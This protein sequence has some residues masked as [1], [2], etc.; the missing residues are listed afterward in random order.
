MTHIDS[1][2][3]QCSS[4]LYLCF[5]AGYKFQTVLTKKVKLFAK[6]AQQPQILMCVCSHHMT[7][8]K[9]MIL[10]GLHVHLNMNVSVFVCFS[11]I[12]TLS[13]L[14]EGFLAVRQ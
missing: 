3:N 9:D 10:C 6:Q 1:K 7:P 5:A 4:V 12:G 8:G 14:M 11:P 13:T 2:K